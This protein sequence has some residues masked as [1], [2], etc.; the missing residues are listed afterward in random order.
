MITLYNCEGEGVNVV[1]EANDEIKQLQERNRERVELVKKT[2]GTKYLLH[3]ENRRPRLTT[4][5]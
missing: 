2:M 1:L 4:P 3:P 5:R